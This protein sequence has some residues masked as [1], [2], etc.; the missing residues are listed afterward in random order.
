MNGMS[1]L[2]F[3]CHT[4]YKEIMVSHYCSWSLDKLSADVADVY[5]GGLVCHVGHLVLGMH[6]KTF[7]ML[8]NI[9]SDRCPSNSQCARMRGT[10]S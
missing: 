6:N 7:E 8:K 4:Y 10:L 3:T 9:I 2:S 5:V 1:S